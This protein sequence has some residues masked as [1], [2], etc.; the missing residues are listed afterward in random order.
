MKIALTGR[1]ERKA[2]WTQKVSSECNITEFT[3][4]EELP[5]HDLL[6]DLDFDD[7]PE[8]ILPYAQLNTPLL[9]SAVKVQLLGVLAHFGIRQKKNIFG[10][11]ALPTF[12][13]R[14]LSE[15]SSAFPEE[16]SGFQPVL[17]QLGLK[18]EWVDDR[19]GMVTPRILF[20]IINEAFYTVQEGTAERGDIDTAMKLGT[21]YP[22]GPFEWMEKIGVREVYE[23]LDALYQDTREERYKT[24][25]LLK[26]EYLGSALR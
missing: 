1:A 8:R 23:V 14:E 26:T 10:I 22:Y 6:V 24:C 11:N 16:R 3:F 15:M 5:E 4:G 9:L 18:P 12:I 20:M 13:N 25:P 21:A 17:D 19:T 2:E 7:Y